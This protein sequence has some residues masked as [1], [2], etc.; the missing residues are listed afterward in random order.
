[1]PGRAPYRPGSSQHH[2]Q[3]PPVQLHAQEQ[4]GQELGEQPVAQPAGKLG[5]SLPQSHPCLSFPN[6]SLLKIPTFITHRV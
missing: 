5:M 1:M 3:L 4:T 6:P 2:L